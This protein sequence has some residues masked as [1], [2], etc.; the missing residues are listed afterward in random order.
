MSPYSLEALEAFDR[1]GRKWVR[2][3]VT[4]EAFAQTPAGAVSSP[5]PYPFLTNSSEALDLPDPGF[6]R[7]SV[8]GFGCLS[9]GL[10]SSGG[11]SRG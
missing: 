6:G 7:L 11:G 3:S 5:F 4:Q 2:V 8:R 9:G 1:F 10:G